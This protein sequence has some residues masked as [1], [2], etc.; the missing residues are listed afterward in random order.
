MTEST[1]ELI[2]FHT[3][4]RPPWW[5]GAT[6]PAAAGLSPGSEDR[7]TRIEI[8]ES[9]FSGRRSAASGE[10]EHQ[11]GEAENEFPPVGRQR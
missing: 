2:D 6:N 4:I 5:E 3:H 7:V 8:A 1:R 10:G 11:R 9:Q